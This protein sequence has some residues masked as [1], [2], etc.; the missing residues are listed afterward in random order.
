M[1]LVSEIKLNSKCI[2][3]LRGLC[4]MNIY[5]VGL[6]GHPQKPGTGRE[7][8][9]RTHSRMCN[10]SSWSRR[11]PESGRCWHS[12]AASCRRSARRPHRCRSQTGSSYRRRWGSLCCDTWRS[13]RSGW[14]LGCT[15]VA[16]WRTLPPWRRKGSGPRS[17][18]G[19]RCL[20]APS[21]AQTR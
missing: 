11:S 12:S 7:G 14:G 9:G 16:P 1:Y 8:Q 15:A 20:S 17:Q 19:R 4:S 3:I 21:S 5:G 13:R 2:C 6:L 18:P 10:S